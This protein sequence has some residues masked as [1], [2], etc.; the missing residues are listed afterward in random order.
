MIL[1]NEMKRILRPGILI[2]IVCLTVIWYLAFMTNCNVYIKNDLGQPY[3]VAKEY[4][5]RFGPSIDGKSGL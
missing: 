3:A 2:I 4:A 5:Q 1:K